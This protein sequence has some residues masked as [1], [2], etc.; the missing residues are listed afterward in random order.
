MK[1]RRAELAMVGVTVIWGSTFVLVKDALAD[2]STILFI[3]LRFSLAALALWFIYS[4]AVRARHAGWK[5]LGPGV[6]AGLLLFGSYY[7]QTA[8]LKLTTPSKSAFITGLS[9]PMVPLASSI[10]YRVKPRMLEVAGVVIASFGMGLMTLPDGAFEISRGDLLSLL[11]AVTFAAHL[12]VMSHYTPIVGFE[13]VAVLQV[14]TAAVLGL[15]AFPVAEPVVFLPSTAVVAAVAITGLLATALAFT[16][17]SW[18]QQYT[19]AT[20]TALICALEPVVAWVTSWWLTG[21]TMPA[22]GQIGAGF[23]L[24]GI[25]L[26]ELRRPAGAEP[27]GTQDASV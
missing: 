16:T 27:T 15:M 26:V 12:V 8:G 21:E 10:V 25:L 5:T 23:I 11:C 14:V 22:R 17:M 6:F 7:F 9:I 4:R 20:R 24:G 1:A 18:A 13:T 2:I 3:A 19:T